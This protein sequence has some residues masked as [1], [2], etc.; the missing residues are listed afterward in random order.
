MK[1]IQIVTLVTPDGAYGGPVRVAVNQTRALLEAGHEVELVAG[2][3]GFGATLPKQFDGVPINLFHARSLPGMGFSG[4]W[5]PGL[6]SWL[7]SVIRTA[8][9]VHIHMGRDM[10]TLPASQLARRLRVP[11]VLQTHGM[12]TRSSHPLAGIVDRLWTFPALENARRVLYLTPQESTDLKS[13]SRP[14]PT[15]E[16]LPNGVP[17]SQHSKANKSKVIEVL[18]LARL[19]ERKRPLLFIE[20]AKKLHPIFPNVRFSMVGPDGG[21]ASDVTASIQAS[22]ISHVL[23]WEGAIPPDKTAARIS[24]CD[25]YVLPSINEPFPMS[26]LEALS[27]GKPV[28]I[29]NSCGL[30]PAILKKEAGMVVDETL[31][32]LVDSVTLLLD[33]AEFRDRVSRAALDLAYNDFGMKKIVKH[34]ENIYDE[35]SNN[36]KRHK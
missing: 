26:V 29:T 36:G 13:L 19:H 2:G 30:G 14:L 3:S 34:L 12:I 32:S 4:T 17:Q 27:L 24:R 6:Q 10:V 33:D 20:L 23:Q 28:V 8:D 1:I 7:R 18:F 11:Y 31:D 16:E 9:A 5:A 25:V 35:V 22:G 15:L 21:Q